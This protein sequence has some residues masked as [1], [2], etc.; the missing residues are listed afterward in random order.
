MVGKDWGKPAF[1]VLS[2]LVERE[3]ADAQEGKES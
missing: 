3:R 1:S 2:L